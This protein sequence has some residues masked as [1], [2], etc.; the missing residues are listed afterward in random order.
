[1]KIRN[2]IVL[3]VIP[4]LVTS[5]LVS[6][7]IGSVSAGRALR[8]LLDKN[9]AFK[10]EELKK[11]IEAQ[12]KLLAENRL[13][14]DTYKK[15]VEETV[16]SYAKS[17]IQTKTE[18][19]IIL[20]NNPKAAVISSVGQALKEQALPG[21]FASLIKKQK[22]GSLRYELNGR[23]RVGIGFPF[24]AFSW[25]VVF[26]EDEEVFLQSS[27]K[28][29]LKTVYVMLGSILF[30][31]LFLFFLS[32]FLTRPI[33]NVVRVMQ[34]IIRSNNLS[35]QVPVEDDD[36]VGELSEVFNVMISELD[37][38]YKQIKNYA[39]QAVLARK[40]EHK[41]RNIFQKYVPQNVIDSFLTNP[42]SMLKGEDRHLAVLFTDIRSFTSISEKYKPDELVSDL[43]RYFDKMVTV[44]MDEGGIIDKYI[45]DAIMAFFGAPVQSEN[46]ALLAVR[47]AL[48]MQKILKKFNRE[49]EENGK[50]VFKT[51]IGINYGLVTVGNIGT[52]KKMDYTVIGDMVNL[53][54]RMEG[55]TKY[56]KQSL[57]FSESIH[58]KIRDSLFS[59]Q[60]GRVKVKGKEKGENI[61]T[62]SDDL[63]QTEQQAWKFHNRGVRLFYRRD[64]Y[65][66]G[67]YFMAALK[68]IPDDVASR[69]YFTE[70]K[71]FLRTPP[72]ADWT[73][74]REMAEK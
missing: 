44:I 32:R 41:L 26:S 5:L 6:G 11:Q 39:F 43:N 4:I 24:P 3:V 30:A 40:N 16:E 25:Y 70:S 69:S 64:F 52:E 51:G 49:Q 71:A 56:Y 60:I 53:A 27:R 21:I 62:A 66:A 47:S 38:V 73:G 55:L 23:A 13:L 2:K 28:I 61:F 15:A 22:S 8:E 33:Q 12:W 57:I 74:I 14:N 46:D 72:P 59:R 50:P 9:L 65:Y 36:E 7:I 48:K 42:A 54:S 20:R 68:L 18:Q 45:G 67:K 58:E 37:N 29:F 17:L 34:E 10:S 19:M 35:Q 1:M 31:V 63:S